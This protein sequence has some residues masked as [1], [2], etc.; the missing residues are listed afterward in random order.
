MADSAARNAAD[1]ATQPKMP[2]WAAIISRPTRWNSG[3]YEPTQSA[4]T[5]HSYPRSLASR[6][7]VCTQTS[8]V[9]P[10]TTRLVMPRS[11]SRSPKVGGVERALA[12][13]VDDR[14]AGQRARARR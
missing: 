13:L 8:V 2:P 9:T 7:V 5:R 6:T 14:L 10:V 3:K 12:G 11:A 1:G 4:S